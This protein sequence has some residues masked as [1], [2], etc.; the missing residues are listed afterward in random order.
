MWTTALR[1][2]GLRQVSATAD[3]ANIPDD[4]PRVAAVIELL[5]G[6]A[7]NHREHSLEA[8]GVELDSQPAPEETVMEYLARRVRGDLRALEAS[9][10]IPRMVQWAADRWFSWRQARQMRA[11]ARR[12]VPPSLDG[13]VAELRVKLRRRR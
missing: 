13:L 9:A 3:A 8:S 7:D 6:I 4:D 2:A 11:L 5:A 10:R 1:I 12:P